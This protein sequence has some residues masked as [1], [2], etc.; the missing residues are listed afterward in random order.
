MFIRNSPRFTLSVSAINS[1][2]LEITHAYHPS[3]ITK[4]RDPVKHVIVSSGAPFTSH[5]SPLSERLEQAKRLL[6]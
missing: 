4:S 2:Q 5:R 1:L 6:N 3:A